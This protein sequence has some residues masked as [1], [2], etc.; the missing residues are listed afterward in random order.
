MPKYCVISVLIALVPM[1]PHAWSAEADAELQTLM[2]EFWQA[3][4]EASP[5]MAT[6]LGVAG[7]DHRLDAVNEPALAA[8]V[9]HYDR[10][11]GRLKAIDSERLSATNKINQGVLEWILTHERTTLASSWR[12]IRFTTFDGWHSGFAQVAALTQFRNDDSSRNY[13]TR[14]AQF[15][16]YANE[17]ITLLRRGMALGYVQPC[18]ALDGYADSIS[19][20]I[21]DEPEQSVFFEPFAKAA[22]GNATFRAERVHEVKRVITS[23]VNP[24]LARY[25]EFFVT[26]YQAA[27][28]TSAGLSQLAGG[29]ELYDHFVRFFTTLDTNASSVHALGLAEVKRIRAE[30]QTIIDELDFE[31]GFD[32]FMTHL[33]TDSKFYP[34]NAEAYLAQA[35]AIAKRIDGK[36]PE[37]FAY[38]PRNPYG[39]KAVPAAVAP[40]T[41]TA[42]YQRG[43]ADG[44]RAGQYFLNLYDLKSRPL[45]E[46]TAL[47]LHEA[48]PGHHLQI[49][50]QQELQELPEFRRHY[51]FHAYG[52]GWGLYAEHLGEEMGMYQTPYD[53]FGRLVYEMWRACRLVVDTGIHAKGWSRDQAI[54]YMA[55]NTALSI[56]NITAEVDRYMTWPGQALA[57]KH[58]E[59]KIK[60]LRTAAE[61][62]L[63]E[64]FSLRDFHALVLTTGAVPLSVL[65]AAV[66]GWIEAAD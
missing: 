5:L 21:A 6:A 31:G 42:Y 50:I 27:C 41:T 12:Y 53:R 36:L 45:Y 22:A 52:E 60:A 24:A 58:G 3:E 51:Y 11:L 35:A 1:A 4:L 57:Y 43:A 34:R 49:S 44:S 61:Q 47:T 14:L 16:R 40:K 10:T 39:I 17:N 63:G 13:L 29:Q 26:E 65:D 18:A 56:H 37:Y 2:E 59:L 46:L 38:L 32:D 62:A 64:R 9:D 55:A 66:R 20:Y 8:R 28:R 19:G 54:D 7:F 33:R 15:G 48:V 25:R 30:M 23:V